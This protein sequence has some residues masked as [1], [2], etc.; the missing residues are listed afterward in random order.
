MKLLLTIVCLSLTSMVNSASCAQKCLRN[1]RFYKAAYDALQ[2]RCGFH[3]ASVQRDI[4]NRSEALRCL[5]LKGNPTSQEIKSAYYDVVR[6]YHPDI[7]KSADAPAM[8]RN[9]IQAKDMLLNTAC[10]SFYTPPKAAY[11]HRSPD[12]NNSE[13][14][15]RMDEQFQKTVKEM[16]MRE[17]LRRAKEMELNAAMAKDRLEQRIKELYTIR[18][19]LEQELNFDIRQKLENDIAAHK[20]FLDNSYEDFPSDEYDMLR[21]QLRTMYRDAMR[22]Y[23]KKFADL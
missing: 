2:S 17:K 9:A 11:S 18:E 5:G 7:N 21:Q 20:K 19:Q 22:Q 14:Y 8:T 10:G 6:K 3:T 1:S 16:E 4:G 12:E 23:N 13:T 15:R